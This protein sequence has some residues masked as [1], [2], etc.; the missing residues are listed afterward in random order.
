M[1][2]QV[3]GK[4]CLLSSCVQVK[5]LTWTWTWTW[6]WTWKASS[7]SSYIFKNNK[8]IPRY[9]KIECR[10][11]GD[12]IFV[13]FFILGNDICHWLYS[14][15]QNLSSKKYGLTPNKIGILIKIIKYLESN[16][17]NL[18]LCGSYIRQNY[19]IRSD[20]ILANRIHHHYIPS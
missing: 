4:C 6:I 2:T 13:C 11:R 17:H 18:L 5:P 9:I 3:T 14:C 20:D 7:H 12:V 16:I 8:I 19:L 10:V 15:L 1:G